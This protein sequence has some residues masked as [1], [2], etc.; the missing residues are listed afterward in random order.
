MAHANEDL[1]RGGYEAFARG[2]VGDVLARFAD[3]IVW[4]VPGRNVLAGEYHGHAGVLG[5]FARLQEL[6]GGTFRLDIHDVMASDGH[7]AVI[8][9]ATAERAGQAWSSDNVHVWHVVD[10]KAT[11]FRGFSA[12]PYADD[13]FWT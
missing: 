8:V 4:H 1:I 5:F 11:R 6:T 9:H 2:D 13:E 3:D 7:V 12:D 10:G